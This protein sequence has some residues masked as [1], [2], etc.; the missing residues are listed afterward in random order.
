[1]SFVLN[2][3]NT[4]TG[5]LYKDDKA[6]LAWETGNELYCPYSWTK[7]IAAHIKSLDSN[8]LVW[9]GFYIGNKEIQPEA[10]DDSTS[11]L[12]RAIT[13]LV[14]IPALTKW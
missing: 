8:H 4:Y 7:Q 6:I 3:R 14:R 1:V 13:I 12:F 10:L 5:T 9:D 2:R 11:I